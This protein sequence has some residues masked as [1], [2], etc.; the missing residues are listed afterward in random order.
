ML[1]PVCC[2]LTGIGHRHTSNA[3]NA[4]SIAYQPVPVTT[5]RRIGTPK[6]AHL[7]GSAEPSLFLSSEPD[8]SFD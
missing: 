4:Q 3:A 2:E 6:A 7:N 1:A 5:R 8:F